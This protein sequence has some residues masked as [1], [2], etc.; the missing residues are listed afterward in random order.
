MDRL[1]FRYTVSAINP[2]VP[3]VSI[4]L[5]GRGPGEKM[6]PICAEQVVQKEKYLPRRWYTAVAGRYRRIVI[7]RHDWYAGGRPPPNTYLGR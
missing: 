4:V 6:Y 2:T 7:E 1:L 3:A 5:L